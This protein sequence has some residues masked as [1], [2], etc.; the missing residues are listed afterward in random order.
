MAV[1]LLL[2][3]ATDPS[4]CSAPSSGGSCPR[5]PAGGGHGTWRLFR[6]STHRRRRFGDVLSTKRVWPGVL[7][8]NRDLATDH[9][10]AAS[11]VNELVA[12]SAAGDPWQ[13]A[14]PVVMCVRACP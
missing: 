14:G 9:V 4:A 12:A 3:H 7:D 8:P 10:G 2:D 5:D 11:E 13:V 1:F 6:L